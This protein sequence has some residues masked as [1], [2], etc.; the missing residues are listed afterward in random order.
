MSNNIIHDPSEMRQK[1]KE[2][3]EKVLLKEIREFFGNDQ[4]FEKFHILNKD[5][6]EL[7]TIGPDVTRGIE[8]F[9]KIKLWCQEMLESQT[10][11]TVKNTVQGKLVYVYCI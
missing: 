7:W 2:N 3:D 4:E 5:L 9:R 11:S 8:D 6:V 1:K 10:I